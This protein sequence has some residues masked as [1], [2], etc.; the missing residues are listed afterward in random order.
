M[1]LGQIMSHSNYLDLFLR[2]LNLETLK[3]N[4][5]PVSNSKPVVILVLEGFIHC[6]PIIKEMPFSATQLL[7]ACKPSKR[8]WYETSL[9]PSS[10]MHVSTLYI[11]HYTHWL[12]FQHLAFYFILVFLLFS[13]LYFIHKQLNPLLYS[14]NIFLYFSC[15]NIQIYCCHFTSNV[16]SKHLYRASVYYPWT[17]WPGWRP[18]PDC[19]P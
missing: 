17:A 19:V 2:T 12:I 11:T 16:V 18:Q 8:H 1:W 3:D 9:P 6:L 7:L 13:K 14:F 10:N 5:M 15:L 4:E